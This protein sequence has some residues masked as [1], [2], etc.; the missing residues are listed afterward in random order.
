MTLTRHLPLEVVRLCY[1]EDVRSRANIPV[2][3]LAQAFATVPREHYLG[4]GPWDVV[5]FGDYITTEDDDPRHL[6]HD[7]LVALDRSRGVNNGQPSAL[8][9]WLQLLDLEPGNRVYHAGCGVG[10]YTAILAEVVGPSGSVLAVEIDPDLASR[11]HANLSH[12]RNV[13]VVTADAITYDPGE[14]DAIFINAGVTHP[15]LLWLDRLRPNGRLVVPITVVR[16][17]PQEPKGVFGSGHMLL[18]RHV[19]ETYPASFE[20]MVAIYSSPTGRDQTFNAALGKLFQETILE[21][22]AD[23][24]SVRRDPHQPGETCWLHGE[25]FCLSSEAP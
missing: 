10:Y 15:Q 17:A 22:R 12:L 14:R 6:Y 1:A 9:G 2:G 23:V 8:A 25:G 11:A 18:V 3:R 5:R 7:D 21:K 16:P 24:R 4:G 13:K 20:S 19:H